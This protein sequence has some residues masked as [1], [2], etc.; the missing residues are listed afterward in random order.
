M[1]P[2]RDVL[3]DRSNG[4][5]VYHLL[6]DAQGELSR[7]RAENERLRDFLDGEGRN[8]PSSLVIDAVLYGSGA[9]DEMHVGPCTEVEKLRAGISWARGMCSDE[10][11]HGRIDHFLGCVLDGTSD[12]VGQ[13]G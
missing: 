10:E 7:L 8:C 1:T 13:H 2:E 12:E 9:S 6:K 5:T 4:P 3:S 11:P